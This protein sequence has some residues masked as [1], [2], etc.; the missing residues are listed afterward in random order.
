MH[1]LVFAE[2]NYIET[3]KTPTCFDRCRIIVKES[4]HKVNNLQISFL[5]FCVSM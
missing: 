2:L 4:L 3:V 1:K 5:M